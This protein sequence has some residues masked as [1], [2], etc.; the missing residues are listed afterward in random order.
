LGDEAEVRRHIAVDLPQ[1]RQLEEW[2]QPDLFETSPS[3]SET[4]GLLALMLETLDPADYRPTLPPNT[5]WSNWPDS[6]AL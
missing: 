6:G 2:N 4:Y 5:H 1:L 3:E